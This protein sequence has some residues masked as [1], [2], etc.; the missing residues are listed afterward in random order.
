[1]PSPKEQVKCMF[2]EISP[3]YDLLNRLLSFGIDRYWRNR[4]IREIRNHFPGSTSQLLM[5]DVATGTG[6]LA[7]AAAGLH[8]S[9][10][11]GLDISVSMMAVAQKKVITKELINVIRFHEGE[12]EN[13]PFDSNRYDVAM[14]AFG[15]RNFHDLQA[16]ISEMNRV[17]KPGGLLLILEF[18]QPQSFP[19]KPLYQLYSKI[20]PL[21]GRMV[22]RHDHAYTYLPETVARF[23]YGETFLTILRDAGWQKQKQIPL[24]GGIATIYCAEK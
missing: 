6:D 3:R 16:G 4:L 1:M 21:F 24:S 15:V 10:I 13:M 23:P 19:L 8:P 11:D 17:L 7:I 2:D 12:A 5:L 14:V 9:R 18:S 20:I 22:S